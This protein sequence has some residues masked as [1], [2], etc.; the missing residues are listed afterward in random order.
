LARLS[1]IGN[2]DADPY[3]RD[4]R[5]VMA[6]FIPE[7]SRNPL[8]VMWFLFLEHLGYRRVIPKRESVF[9]VPAEVTEAYQPIGHDHPDYSPI[10]L[11]NC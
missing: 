9:V 11:S 3:S 4:D 2:A 5:I 7:R 10:Q 8:T 6:V 1:E